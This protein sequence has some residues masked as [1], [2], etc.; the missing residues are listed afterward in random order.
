MRCYSDL[1]RSE[2]L[3][4]RL[5]GL[6]TNRIVES[7]THYEESR[8]SMTRIFRWTFNHRSEQRSYRAGDGGVIV[9]ENAR[10]CSA[11]VSVYSP[12]PSSSSISL[13]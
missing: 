4:Y 8:T 7:F 9:L 1:K 5:A 2:P 12:S 13:L 10:K 11:W 3:K 6:G